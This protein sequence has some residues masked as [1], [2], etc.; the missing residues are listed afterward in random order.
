MKFR[1]DPL[2]G[3]SMGIRLFPSK[4]GIASGTERFTDGGVTSKLGQT[5]RGLSG[6]HSEGGSVH[7]GV[8]R[9]VTL[10]TLPV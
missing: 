8:G 2:F 5:E 3:T 4:G 7:L 6:A 9:S 10:G 1:H